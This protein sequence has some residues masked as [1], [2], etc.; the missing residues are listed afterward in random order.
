MISQTHKFVKGLLKISLRELQ[1]STHCCTPF[2]KELTNPSIHVI[3]DDIDHITGENRSFFQCRRGGIGRR[4]GLKIRFWLQ[5]TGSSPVGGTQIIR[6][7]LFSMHSPMRMT[8][9]KATRSKVYTKI[10]RQHRIK[11]IRIWV[12]CGVVMI[13]FFPVN[14]EGAVSV[15]TVLQ[16]IIL[17]HGCQVAD[18]LH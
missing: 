9:V 15:I 18:I 3:M 14:A 2:S 12:L 1:K 11:P 10:I 5:S 8:R 16:Q 13:L 4:S 7:A 17:G 6:Y